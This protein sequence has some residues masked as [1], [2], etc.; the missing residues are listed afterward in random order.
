MKSSTRIIY[1]AFTLLFVLP[2]IASGIGF[3]VAAPPVVEGMKHLGYPFYFIRFLGVA[4][5]LGAVAVLVGRFPR[6][7]E[8]A[9]AGFVFNL[10]GAACSHL[11]SGDGPK[12]LG[13]LIILLFEGISYFYWR[14]QKCERQVLAIPTGAPE[15]A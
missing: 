13:P 6:I 10:I 2:L 1:W 11:C 3:A 14:K 8:W 9:Y 4:K 12:A 5:L 7:K 15:A